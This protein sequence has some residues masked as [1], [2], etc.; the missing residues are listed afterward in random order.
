MTSLPPLTMICKS[1]TECIFC[2]S[3]IVNKCNYQLAHFLWGKFINFSP[4]QNLGH[5]FLQEYNCCDCFLQIVKPEPMEPT[6]L[7]DAGAVISNFGSPLLLQLKQSF[8]AFIFQLNLC[9]SY[10]VS[11]K[12]SHCH[13]HLYYYSI[14]I[15]E[16]KETN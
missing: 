6:A 4:S 13:C 12:I 14:I 10:Y 9:L 2:F 15:S 16:K 5:N 7:W 8:Q 3:C 1:G 11:S